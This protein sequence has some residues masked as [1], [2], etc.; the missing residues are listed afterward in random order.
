MAVIITD[1]PADEL[2]GAD[3][4]RKGFFDPFQ[5]RLLNENDQPGP[6]Q[7]I[8]RQPH[9]G[10]ASDAGRSRLA[11]VAPA[12]QFLRREAAH[13]VLRQMNSIFFIPKCEPR[14]VANMNPP[15]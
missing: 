8:L 6:P 5:M 1:L 9:L 15:G 14:R 3:H 12:E 10:V 2:F 4:F 11:T 13:P 7:K